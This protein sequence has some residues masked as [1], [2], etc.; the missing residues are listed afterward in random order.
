VESVHERIYYDVRKALTQKDIVAAKDLFTSVSQA[1]DE[2]TSESQYWLFLTEAEIRRFEKQFSKVQKLLEQAYCLLPNI[3]LTSQQQSSLHGRMGYCAYQLGEFKEALNF[4]FSASKLVVSDVNRYYYYKL[5]VLNC[6]CR[7]SQRKDFL[8]DIK[9]IISEL[10]ASTLVQYWNHHLDFIWEL[11]RLIHASPWSSDI[12]AFLN[13]FSPPDSITNYSDC[14]L[15]YILAH[16]SRLSN[17]YNLTKEY[18]DKSLQRSK[19]TKDSQDQMLLLVNFATMVKNPF[20]DYQKV[21]QLL[22][23]ALDYTPHPSGWRAYILNSLGS[24]L[25]FTGDY[26]KAITLLKESIEFNT[27]RKYFWGLSFSH[28]TLGMI[29]TLIGDHL[30]AQ[31]HFKNSLDYSLKDNNPNGEGYAYGAMGW[32]E[33]KLGNFQKAKELYDKSLTAFMKG[34]FSP[35]IILLAQ[36][37]TISQLEDPSSSIVHD[38]LSRAQDQIWRSKKRLDKGRYYVSLGNIA[39]NNQKLDQADEEYSKALEYA[40]THE[41]ETQCLM[42]KAKV[43]IEKFIQTDN[44]EN[45]K[46]VKDIVLKLKIVTKNNFTLLWAEMELISAILNIYEGNFGASEEKLNSLRTYSEKNSLLELQSRIEKQEHTLQIYQRYKNIKKSLQEKSEEDELRIQS[47]RDVSEYLKMV[48]HILRSYSP[49]S[50][51]KND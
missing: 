3:S 12:V 16:I 47:M 31:D 32:C 30:K 44:I 7:L 34:G 11:T 50:K 10:F 19:N 24:V 46:L 43:N 6:R 25:R 20:G 14:F 17:D 36:A 1:D 45:L 38:L 42:G 51:R 39:F 5:M 9:T 27:E 37:E 29:Y 18:I 26:Q 35:A 13:S 48:T 2:Y 21:K 8:E 28:N 23:K 49:D 41:V 22:L 40:D 33:T 15:D 4:Y